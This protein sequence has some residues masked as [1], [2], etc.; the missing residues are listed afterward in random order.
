MKL[1]S[2][3]RKNPTNGVEAPQNALKKPGLEVPAIPRPVSEAQ[4]SDQLTD[5]ELAEMGLLPMR[6]SRRR[7]AAFSG[8]LGAVLVA[9]VKLG[10][11]HA[12][13]HEMHSRRVQETTQQAPEVAPE[14][15]RSETQPAVQEQEGRIRVE[16]HGMLEGIGMTDQEFA[17]RTRQVF[18]PFLREGT[19]RFTFTNQS[20]HYTPAYF[21]IHG[22]QGHQVHAHGHG[23]D[24]GT[25]HARPGTTNS[26]G[27]FEMANHRFV[28]EQGH[29]ITL[30]RDGLDPT[31]DYMDIRG[32]WS[33]ALH[34]VIHGLG[35][36]NKAAFEARVRSRHRVPYPY[37][38][39]FLDVPH[40][41]TPDYGHMADEYRS[42]TYEMIFQVRDIPPGSTVEAEAIRVIRER[43]PEAST[44]VVRSDVQAALSLLPETRWVEVIREYHELVKRSSDQFERQM[45]HRRIISQVPDAELASQLSHVL[46]QGQ[47]TLTGRI[48]DHHEDTSEPILVRELV[49]D[50]REY[51][52]GLIHAIEADMAAQHPELV[53]M[54]QAWK[55]M[56]RFTSE[57]GRFHRGQL[58]AEERDNEFATTV[59]GRDVIL[60]ITDDHRI[61]QFRF[62]L[63]NVSPTNFVQA[64]NR[65][66]P[67][68]RDQLRP[69][70]ERMARLVS[71]TEPLPDFFATRAQ[72]AQ[73]Q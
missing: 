50:V 39:H 7:T 14:Q 22:D 41:Q 60:R 48:L 31:K 33:N 29:D 6:P 71:H 40:G 61:S 55:E 59:R 13:A 38:E 44:S 37:T 54:L 4:N 20:H 1:F 8:L 2:P 53:P 42:K 67:E 70:L 3:D 18:A 28:G 23:H 43:F 65:L 73:I 47:R 10:V 30:R 72:Q 36:E 26:E 27:W 34:E 49:R 52:Q 45:L 68:V 32:F 57:R 62:E 51:H 58:E 25:T 17:T 9:A 11:S 19:Y 66:S 5:A 35:H 46:D 63:Q 15:P 12:G 64:W 56:A 16:A 69:T 21:G 24:R